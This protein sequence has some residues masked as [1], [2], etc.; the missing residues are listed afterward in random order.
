MQSPLIKLGRVIYNVKEGLLFVDDVVR[1]LLEIEGLVTYRL[2]DR[3]FFR[4][5]RSPGEYL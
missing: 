5:I 4:P 3:V 1:D 2:Q